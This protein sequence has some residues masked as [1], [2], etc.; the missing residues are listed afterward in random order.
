M[1]YKT[2][3]WERFQK[4]NL[5]RLLQVVEDR[6]WRE[7]K[8]QALGVHLKVTVW[9]FVG[10]SLDKIC[11]NLH[12]EQYLDKSLNTYSSVCIANKSELFMG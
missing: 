3:G 6:R 9:L 5:S 10:L 2:R 8:I 4:L 12:T 7:L 1:I 11:L